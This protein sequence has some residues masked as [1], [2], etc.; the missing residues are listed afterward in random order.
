M[1]LTK[2]HLPYAKKYFL[3]NAT[4]DQDVNI[5]LRSTNNFKLKLTKSQERVIVKAWI[6]RKVE[7]T[8]SSPRTILRRRNG[9]TTKIPS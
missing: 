9:V 8:E 4:S 3:S 7:R 5:I 6:D 1:N 2:D